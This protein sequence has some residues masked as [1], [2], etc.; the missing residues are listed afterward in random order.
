MSISSD[1]M[2]TSILVHCIRRGPVRARVPSGLYVTV[3]T[4]SVL[5]LTGG[6]LVDRVA[7]PVLTT[8]LTTAV[9]RTLTTRPVLTILTTLTTG[10]LAPINASLTAATPIDHISLTTGILIV[11]LRSAVL[12]PLIG[13]IYGLGL[14]LIEEGRLGLR[15]CILIHHRRWRGSVEVHHRRWT[16]WGGWSVQGLNV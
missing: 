15:W 10:G 1:C 3:L 6:I 13:T 16:R 12:V 7:T 5:T 8:S 2:T 11:G 4:L 9:L 14:R